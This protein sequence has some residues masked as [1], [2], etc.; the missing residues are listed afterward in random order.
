MYATNGSNFSQVNEK[1][2]PT[3]KPKGGPS[4]TE[5]FYRMEQKG[6]VSIANIISKPPSDRDNIEKQFFVMFL[7]LRVPFFRDFDKKTLRFIMERTSSQFFRK[8]KTV[9]EYG[10]D[11]D[12]M[13]VVIDGQ[14]ACYY[15][16]HISDITPDQ[17]PDQTVDPN[18][19]WGEDCMT[20]EIK[21]DYSVRASKKTLVMSIDKKD[22]IEVL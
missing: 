9:H 13:I 7:K 22:L 19:A 20:E 12:H 17:E 16:R 21:W 10:E 11:G 6:I 1:V 4:Q 18:E 5:D 2:T 15:Q 14:L 3:K 8:G